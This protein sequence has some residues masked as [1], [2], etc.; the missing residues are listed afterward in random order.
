MLYLK[1]EEFDFS[2]DADRELLHGSCVEVADMCKTA[3]QARK[4]HWLKQLLHMGNP[5]CD[6]PEHLH[7]HCHFTDTAEDVDLLAEA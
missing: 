2:L 1:S 3:H 7:A 6:Q 4:A 5:F